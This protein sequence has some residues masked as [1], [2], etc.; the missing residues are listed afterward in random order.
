M[1][2]VCNTNIYHRLSRRTPSVLKNNEENFLSEALGDLLCR[3]T[4]E[5]TA[6]FMKEVLLKQ[7]VSNLWYASFIESWAGKSL[8]WETQYRIT[9]DEGR[10]LWPDLVLLADHRPI[11]VIEAKLDAPTYSEQLREYA[12]WLQRPGKS[13]DRPT[14]VVLLRNKGKPPDYRGI[15]EGLGRDML[16]ILDARWVDVRNW[17]HQSKSASSADADEFLTGLQREFA[18][19]MR[20]RGIGDDPADQ[21]AIEIAAKTWFSGI[22]QACEVVESVSKIIDR[23]AVGFT[24][25]VDGRKPSVLPIRSAIWS[26]ATMLPKTSDVVY[27]SWGL[28]FPNGYDEWHD[29]HTP[30]AGGCSYFLSVES[31]KGMRDH[32][33]SLSQDDLPEKWQIWPGKGL[34]R[35]FQIP[36][37][38]DEGYNLHGRLATWTQ[39][40][41]KEIVSKRATLIR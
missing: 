17:L 33:D 23:L 4:S 10:R 20:V 16:R 19:F 14:A 6:A 39:E 40:A 30:Q 34:V 36:S 37:D 3:L 21:V 27:I 13:P 26:Y 22:E 9:D 15:E 1:N 35:L 38:R 11:L 24:F 7:E 32:V 29:L 5:Q 31:D 2:G 18:G 41:L 8:R 28:Y 25:G 12:S